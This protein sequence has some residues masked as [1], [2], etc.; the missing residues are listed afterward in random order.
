M[1]HEP[2]EFIPSPALTP[3]EKALVPASDPLPMTAG[4]VA[5]RGWPEV[6]VVL[7]TGDAYIDH[8]A[9]FTGRVARLL[10]ADGLRVAVLSQPDARRH[11]AWTEF[12][13]PRLGFCITAGERDSMLAHYT[14]DRHLRG[15]DPLTPGGKPGRRPD[16]ATLAYAQRA[17]EAYP[18]AV[19]VV[20]GVE[21]ALR[22]FAHFDAWSDRVRRSILIDAKAALLAYGSG[23]PALREIYRRLDAG[24][25]VTEL[26]DIRGTAYRIAPDE[27]LP[28]ETESL[29]HL[30]SYEEV[31]GDRAKPEEDRRSKRLFAEMTRTICANLDPESAKVLVQEHGLDAVAVNPPARPLAADETA[32]IGALPFTRKAHPSYGEE[33]IPA[34]GAEGDV[35]PCGEERD[36]PALAAAQYRAAGDMARMLPPEMR[37]SLRLPPA[38]A[39]CGSDGECP[40]SPTLIAGFPGFG[41]RE[42]AELAAVMKAT[43]IR[44]ERILDFVPLPSDA[45]GAVFWTGLDLETGKPVHVARSM[46]E[47]RLQRVLFMFDN[48][49]YY[50]DV[51][52]ALH[53]AGR[54]DLI[55]T[56][57]DALIPPH[58]S[59]A[60][61]LR[62]SS[63]VRLLKRR[64]EREKEAKERTRQEYR[65][66]EEAKRRKE[67]QK[68]KFGS[69]FRSRNPK[70][71]RGAAPGKRSGFGG[72]PRK[73]GNSSRPPR[74]NRPEEGEP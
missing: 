60:E 45:A 13:R 6:D 27:D 10:E 53:E 69:R 39:D 66:R 5:R 47:R 33:A 43:G 61:H 25:R 72:R 49:A 20:A 11:A 74:E 1:K 31:C 17:R 62:Q 50:H 18:D 23:E 16:R 54:E 36:A 68:R 9:F 21:A 51:K 26:R 55:G 67:A 2:Q 70:D 46:R 73:P 44:P 28:E 48:P 24:E 30:P 14:P 4:E 42:A 64:Q 56:G 8:P 15:D 19:I 35:L 7:V 58:L 29:R 32:R 38:V 22:R 57:P 12:G 65:E 63:R 52:A 40:E 41:Y 34:L 3:E 37:E 71:P 59:K